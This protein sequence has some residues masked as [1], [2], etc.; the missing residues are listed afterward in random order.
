MKAQSSADV[1]RVRVRDRLRCIPCVPT[2]LSL[3]LFLTLDG[4]MA[5]PAH[6]QSVGFDFQRSVG[7]QQRRETD[8]PSVSLGETDLYPS[9]RIDAVQTRNA[10][11]KRDDE[12]SA[13]GVLVSPRVLWVADRRL[14][15]LRATYD[16]EYSRNDESALEHADHRLGL[17]LAAALSSR[18]RVSG[19][20]AFTRSHQA[21]GINF[22]RGIADTIDAPV[23]FNQSSVAGAF[24]Y[25][26][27]RARGNLVLGLRVDN[28]AYTNLDFVTSG[29]D[30]LTVEPYALFSLRVS[31]DTRALVELRFSENDF[32]RDTLDRQDTSV[33]VGATFAATGQSTGELKVGASSSTYDSGLRDD[34]I[35]TVIEG[36]FLYQPRDFSFFEFRL[37]R[38]LDNAT[39]VSLDSTSDDASVR[40]TASVDW[41]YDWSERVAQRTFVAYESLTRG[42]PEPGETTIF[43]GLELSL[44]VRRWLEIG[45]SAQLEQGAGVGCSNADPAVDAADLD[46]DM[47]R[48]GIFIRSRL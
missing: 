23:R 38:E 28:R 48:A 31:G 21:P 25:G 40:D 41:Q 17:G 11:R 4:T 16:G 39:G 26:A 43:A 24:T 20:L 46:Y 36:N 29:R 3:A 6:A 44:S 34:V 13:S 35:T 45:G 33:L 37:E 7:E 22:T 12:T 32:D 27:E 2:A 1:G 15:S 14:L 42:C 10:F 9:V 8:G 19:L 47:T 5:L 30:Y 18:V